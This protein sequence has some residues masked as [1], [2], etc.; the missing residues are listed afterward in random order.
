MTPTDVLDKILAALHGGHTFFLSGHEGPD[1]DTVGCEL[2]LG[3]WLKRQGKRVTLCNADPVPKTLAFLHGASKIRQARRVK[4]R[5][6]VAVIFEC[7]GAERMGNLID[8][9]SQAGTVIN[10]DHHSHHAAYGDLNYID[11]TASSNSELLMPLFER[12]KI[13]PTPEEATA[14]YTGLVTDT[15]RFQQSNTTARSHHVAALLM[16][17]GAD[18][19]GVC[20]A[21]YGTRSWAGL[22]LLSLGLGRLSLR[23]GGR[24]CV[25]ALS[26]RDISRL[27]ATSNDTD[28]FSNWG[29][30]VPGVEVSVLAR[31][32]PGKK[33]IKFS[34]RGRG[35]LDLSAVAVHFGGGGHRN[36]AGCSLPFPLKDALRQVTD[37]ISKTLRQKP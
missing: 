7:S 35:Q 14:L 18:A 10:I 2:A 17:C 4:G 31:E 9:K 1:G 19:A 37:Q 28:E 34:L 26:A 6:D 24:V 25:M 3:S 11:P 29:L 16:E 12:A 30:M 20:R 32:R 13:L 33:D 15:G 23:E 5:F 22:Q 21:L 8:F 27:G 36:A